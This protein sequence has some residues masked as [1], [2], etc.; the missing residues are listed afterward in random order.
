M[1]IK[2]IG[3]ILIGAMWCIMMG[4]GLGM[5]FGLYGCL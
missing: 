5:L 4:I 2:K 1:S 3:W